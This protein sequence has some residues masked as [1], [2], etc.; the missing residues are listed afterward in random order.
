MINFLF[1]NFFTSSMQETGSIGNESNGK[2][3]VIKIKNE[4]YVLQN[5]AENKIRN[6][7]VSIITNY[8]KSKP[9]IN[10]KRVYKD[11]ESK[12]KLMRKRLIIFQ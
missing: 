12:K 10:K 8:K 2:N 11:N 4:E 7:F 5:E 3:Q 1:Y 6:D 9:V